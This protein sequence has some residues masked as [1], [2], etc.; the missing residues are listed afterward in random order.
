MGLQFMYEEGSLGENASILYTDVAGISSPN[1]SFKYDFM[2][3]ADMGFFR[4]SKHRKIICLLMSDGFLF[5]YSVAPPLII[6]SI[7]VMKFI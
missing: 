1:S 3:Y 2:P 6:F 5:F 4:R 7:L